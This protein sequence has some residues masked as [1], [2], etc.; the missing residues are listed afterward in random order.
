MSAEASARNPGAAAEPDAGPAK[1]VFAVWVWKEQAITPDPVTGLP[2]Q[3]KVLEGIV[4]PTEV[5]EPPPVPEA[6]AI[7]E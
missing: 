5:T 4:R 2:V 3:R 1:T 7:Y 6:V